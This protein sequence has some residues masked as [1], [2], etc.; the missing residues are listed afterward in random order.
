[1][2]HLTGH[3]SPETAYIVADYPYGF[4]LRC[5]KR[6]WIE[7]KPGHGQ[8]LVTQTS[9]PKK[10]G[11]VWN[12]PKADTYWMILVLVQEDDTGYISTRG[13]HTYG[14]EESLPAFDRDFPDLSE[15]QTALIGKMKSYISVRDTRKAA[16]A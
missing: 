9:N 4:T 7:T 13:L 14:W 16:A 6:Y 3:T 1:M 10:P 5:Q 8:R 12:K 11:V 15:Y 2:K